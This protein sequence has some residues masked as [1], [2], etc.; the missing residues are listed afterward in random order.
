MA[1]QSSRA[2][3]NMV[4]A[5]KDD[6]KE[7]EKRKQVDDDN[8]H[9]PKRTKCPGVRLVGSRI[10]DSENG[11][12]CHQVTLFVVFRIPISVFCLADRKMWENG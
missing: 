5:K 4:S 1:V 2:S 8:G 11:K 6:G 3:R 12:T 7:T 10:Y 9:Q